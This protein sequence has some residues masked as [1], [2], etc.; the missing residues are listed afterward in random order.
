MEPI[1]RAILTNDICSIENLLREYQGK[2]FQTRIDRAVKIYRH[3][4]STTGNYDDEYIANFNRQKSLFLDKLLDKHKSDVQQRQ[5]GLK[6]FLFL[7][8]FASELIVNF[9]ICHGYMFLNKSKWDLTA[10]LSS[11]R[12]GEEDIYHFMLNKLEAPKVN[13]LCLLHHYVRS[14][15]ATEDIVKR[16][17][18]VGVNFNELDSSRCSVLNWATPYGFLR[19]SPEAFETVKFLLEH[20]ADANLGSVCTLAEAAEYG[21]REVV[22]LLLKH[23]ACVNGRLGDATT[24]LAHAASCGRL[25]IVELLLDRGARRDDCALYRAIDGRFYRPEDKLKIV[26]LLLNRGFDVNFAVGSDTVLCRAVKW[27]NWDVVKLLLDY[28]AEVDKRI[29]DDRR[30]P[31]HIA[32]STGDTL[33]TQLLL[34]YG[35][36]INVECE[37]D[38][39]LWELPAFQLDFSTESKL[40]RILTRQLVFLQSQGLHVNNV[41]LEA[42]EE[43]KGLTKY[44]VN[45]NK[46][47]AKLKKRRF[48]N[49]NLFYY[50]LLTTNNDTLRLGLLAGNESI[51]KVVRSDTF[52]K[53][54]PIYGDVVV[55][56]FNRGVSKNKDFVFFKR[57]IDYLSTRGHDRLSKLHFAIVYEIF[58]YLNNRDI[59]N[60]RDL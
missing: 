11:I 4:E 56:Q 14:G 52:K 58:T 12:A 8:N 27:R 29:D 19:N 20:G 33:I 9:L 21:S 51:A 24:P 13:S 42:V 3:E 28:G 39:A 53:K 46:E 50:D 2:L 30:C 5:I 17:W 44:C 35:A 23:G 40:A 49:S 37:G 25:E 15:N 32:V 38:T 59:G 34:D 16:F 22:Q 45:C 31:L 6:F 41:N 60:L 54:F 47:L 1:V 55:R 18:Q 36:D 7:C 48:Y 43:S 57:F 26:K 10:I